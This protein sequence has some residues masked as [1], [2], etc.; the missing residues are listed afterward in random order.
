MC[1]PGCSLITGASG[2]SPADGPPPSDD[3]PLDATAADAGDSGPHPDVGGLPDGAT[4]P[5]A[6]D[7]SLEPIDAERAPDAAPDAAPPAPDATPPDANPADATPPDATPAEGPALPFGSHPA[8]LAPGVF[9]PSA[10]RANLDAATAA[11]YDGWKERYLVEGC[12]P[13]HLRVRT[14]GSAAHYTVSEGQ[15]YGMLIAVYMAGHDPEARDVFDGL[16]R[17]ARAHPSALTPNLM[18]WAQDEDCR[19]VGGDD[20]ATDGDLDIA[21]ALLLADRQWAAKGPS[22]TTAPRGG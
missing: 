9:L 1:L 7:A 17:Y 18:A 3:A 6:E 15:G 20:S 10:P 12:E 19:H 5:E 2:P 14:E 21:Y 16:Y 13:G 8:A 4:S 22:T 11:F